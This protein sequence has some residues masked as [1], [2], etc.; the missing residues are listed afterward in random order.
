MLEFNINNYVK[1]KLTKVGIKELEKQHNELAK[2]FPKIG[3]FVPPKID[4]NGYSSF[5]LHTLMSKF[6]NIMSLCSATPFETTI[7]ICNEEQL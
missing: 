3:L 6:G 2:Y 7:L 1:V 5:Q 4:E